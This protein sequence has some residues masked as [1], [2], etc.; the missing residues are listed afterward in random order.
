MMINTSGCADIN[1]ASRLLS[2]NCSAQ[3]AHPLPT[4]KKRKPA[5]A[6]FFNCLLVGLVIPPLTAEIANMISAAD[7]NLIPAKRN[8]GNS[9]TKILLNK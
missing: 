7:T 9:C 8:G 5:M 2:M 4:V 3:T 6:L 1:N